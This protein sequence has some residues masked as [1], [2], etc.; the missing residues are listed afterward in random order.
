VG[1]RVSP[2]FYNTDDE[3]DACLDAVLDILRTGAW[4]KHA[5]KGTAY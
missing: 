5:Q 2:H 4:Q 1:L 3:L